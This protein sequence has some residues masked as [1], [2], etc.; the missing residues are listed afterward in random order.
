MAHPTSQ[1][2]QRA[3]HHVSH[4]AVIVALIFSA[5]YFFVA[6]PRVVY[7]YDIDFVED[8]MLMQA[9]R[10]ANSQ[11]VFVA[12]NAEFV[13]HVYM[14]LYTWL[15]GWLLKASGPG[16]LPL[17]LLSLGATLAVALTI[18][19]IARR[20]S[21]RR[22]VAIAC[23]GLWLAGYR[24]SDGWYELARV[25]A[26][27]VALALAGC[28]LA[29]YGAS[30]RRGL[31]ASGAL[32]GLALLTKQNA[33]ALILVA[34]IYL[35]IV[36]GRRAWIALL[37]CA[38]VAGA[39]IALLHWSSD[40]WFSTYVFGIAYAS[41]VELARLLD[42]V[43]F[44]LFGAAGALSAGLLALWVRV[45]A[46]A[47]WR[48]LAGRPWPIFVAA[49][50]GVSVLGRASVGGGSNNW[51]IGYAGLCL[52]PALLSAD[53]SSKRWGEIAV[54]ALALAQFALGLYNP[55]RFIPTEAMRAAGDRLVARL[56]AVDGEVLVLLHPYYAVRAGKQPSA[57]IAALWHARWRGRDPLPPDF[58]QRIA[59]RHY[60]VI[61]SDE[62]LFEVDPP[63]LEL[64]EANYA[65]GDALT[66]ADAPPTLTGMLAQPRVVYVPKR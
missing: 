26:L 23:A 62:S 3:S 12:P 39:P 41:P 27:F 50:A 33:I 1:L 48:S 35:P 10:V 44:E 2:V 55:I 52:V 17:R 45:A 38:V 30:S 14:P 5:V 66:D 56:A 40:G 61:V 29:V 36:A 25:D 19:A 58:A 21:G 32:L 47:Q 18:Y 7:P 31:A 8:G 63:L 64:L 49:A 15:G 65:R 20:E 60:A 22:R 37:A 24:I 4:L 51:L 28:A 13:P 34:G 54:S 11:P 53:L 42:V 16:F 59:Q 57:H 46:R 6:I 9:L 43:R